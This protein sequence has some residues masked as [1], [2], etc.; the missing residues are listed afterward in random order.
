[1]LFS[2]AGGVAWAMSTQDAELKKAL[3]SAVSALFYGAILAGVVKLLLDEHD[4]QRVRRAEQAQ[5]IVNV[6]ADLKSVYD[7]VE[8]ARIV[9]TAH[10]SALTYGKEMRGLIEARVKLLNVLRALA[11]DPRLGDRL[12]KVREYVARMADYLERVVREFENQYK[13]ISDAQRDHEARIEGLKQRLT[14]NHAAKM[15][16]I[17]NTPWTKIQALPAM[18]DLLGLS[19]AGAAPAV[20]AQAPGLCYLQCFVA[21]LDAASA[22]LREELRRTLA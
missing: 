22:L 10:Q 13:G 18:Q 9:I 16:A 7:Q 14:K 17:E 19:G 15:P 20:A 12:T 6:L 4:R 5:F 11:T 3:Y 2:L 21:S 1:V 8:S